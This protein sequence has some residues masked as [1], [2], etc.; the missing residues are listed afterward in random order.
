VAGPGNILI[1]VGADTG[2]AVRELQ[3]LDGPL[4]NVESRGA[5]MGAGIRKATLPAIAVLGGLAIAAKGAAQAAAEDEAAAVKLAGALE[6]TTGA[7]AATVA[8]TEAWITAQGL[9]K[10]VSDDELRP[11]MARLASATGSVAEAQ[12][13][14][15]L[16]MDIA[17]QSGKPLETVTKA[18][19]SAYDGKTMA[20]ARLVPGLDK[21]ALASKDMTVITGL[22]ADKVGGAAAEAADTAEGRYRVMQIRMAELRE[23]LGAALLPAVNRVTSAVLSATRVAGEHTTAVKIVIGVIAALAAGVL[24][25]RAAMAVYT[26]AVVAVR[27]ATAVWTAGQWLLN[28]ALTANPIGVVVVAIAALAA[29]VVI[30]YRRSETFRNAVHAAWAVLKNSPLGLVIGHFQSLASAAQSVVGWISQIRWPSPPSWLGKIG[31]ILGAVIPGAAPA[32]ART[33][34]RRTSSRSASP[35]GASSPRASGPLGAGGVGTGI[36]INVYGA[37]DPE[38]TA[39][40]INRTLRAHSRR[41]GALSR[42][43]EATS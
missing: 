9:A 38:G 18:L 4:Q 24:V 11:A 34:A 31:G 3:G 15:S 35:R 28:V 30:A 16:A 39:R 22:L 36:T 6:R 32:A 42:L 29:A 25:A 20:L 21:A 14:T 33:T 7:T 27:A 17:A 12:R 1:R 13:A 19:A 8:A 43:A 10:G 41:Q 26:A 23:E 40:A 5:R 2:A 37:T